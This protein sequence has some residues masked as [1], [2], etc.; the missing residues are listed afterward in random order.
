MKT[1]HTQT[2]D[3][4]R[5]LLVSSDE[6]EALKV[7]TE[8]AFEDYSVVPAPMKQSAEAVF[9]FFHEDLKPAAPARDIQK[10]AFFVT[11]DGDA[12]VPFFPFPECGSFFGVM[13][14][15]EKG[16]E[17]IVPGD[18]DVLY[19]VPM[20]ADGSPDTFENEPNIGEV[21]NAEGI[22]FDDLNAFF[23]TAFCASDFFGR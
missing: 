3:G 20:M 8:I 21:E 12:R 14:G 16:N 13:H 10:P 9:E 11:I 4:S 1:L 6:F 15:V 2:T 22:D 23:G 7:A 5:I 18:D 17:N 19:S